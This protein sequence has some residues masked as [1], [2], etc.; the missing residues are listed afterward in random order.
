MLT[1]VSAI[2]PQ[3]LTS[4]GDGQVDDV[5]RACEMMDA[6]L[7]AAVVSNDVQFVQRVLARYVG[8]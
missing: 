5:L 6:H 2:Y 8:V 4:Y 1:V 7:T 3:V